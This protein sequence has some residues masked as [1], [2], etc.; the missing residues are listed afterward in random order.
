MILEAYAKV[1]FTLEVFAKRADG[2]HALRSVVMPVSLSDTLEV[3]L[4]DGISSDSRYPDDLA[5]KA[6]R[7][8]AREAGGRG[9]GAAI[10]YV[11]KRIPAG[12]GLGGGSADAAAVIVALNTIWG[13]SL[14]SA[15]LAE[16]GARVGSDVPALVLARIYACPVLMEGRGEKVSVLGSG[17][18]ESGPAS[19]PGRRYSALKDAKRTHPPLNLVL[20]NPGVHSS[21]AEVYSKCTSRL[22]DDT[23]I[24]Y[25]IC[26]AL[27]SGEVAAIASALQ[28]DLEPPAV[29]L[30]P[31]IAAVK[32]ALADAGAEGVLMSGSGSTVFGLVP[33]EARGREIAALLEAKGLWA[34]AVRTCPVV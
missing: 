8:L 7:E 29:A 21:T 1:N 4:A 14:P 13:L 3:T 19:D 24:L 22:P 11:E 5:L 15:R 12:G 10:H 20:A 18:V 28:N 26:S 33:T 27:E 23:S 32:A 34:R 6:A 25:N 31:E 9:L 17:M 2:Y 16:V 30:H